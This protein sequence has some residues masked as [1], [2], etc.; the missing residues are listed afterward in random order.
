MK[1]I[2]LSEDGV[3]STNVNSG[4]IAVRFSPSNWRVADSNP[5]LVTVLRS[6]ASSSPLNYSTLMILHFVN[7]LTC[8]KTL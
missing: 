1:L 3:S 6:W 8:V 4:G 5:T 2:G 7:A